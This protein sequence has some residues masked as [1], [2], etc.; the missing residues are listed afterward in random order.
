M[1]EVLHLAVIAGVRRL[2]YDGGMG[3]REP[4]LLTPG[5]P[6]WAGL[7]AE[8]RRLLQT[9]TEASVEELLRRGMRLSRQAGRLGRAVE[10]DLDVD[11]P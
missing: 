3:E 11:R 2:T 4:S 9:A 1:R 10:A 6:A 5:H 7:D 8:K